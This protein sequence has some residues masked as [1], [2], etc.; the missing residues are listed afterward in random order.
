[1]SLLDLSFATDDPKIRA[2]R[3]DWS[4]WVRMWSCAS[5]ASLEK[6]VANQSS[7]PTDQEAMGFGHNNGAYLARYRELF[8]THTI[9]I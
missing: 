6:G 5:E 7:P 3:L 2:N 1:M 4:S 9:S 8:D